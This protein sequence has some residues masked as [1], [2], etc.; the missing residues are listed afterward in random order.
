[1]YFAGQ[2]NKRN[3]N[4]ILEI[5]NYLEKKGVEYKNA[6]YTSVVRDKGKIVATGSCD[7][8]V[9]KYFFV[10]EKY[11]GQG[12]TILIYNDI[13]N[14]LYDNNISEY[15]VFTKPKNKNIFSS[16]GLKEVFQNQD[17]LLLEGGFSDYNSWIESIRSKLDKNAK[18]RGAIV[19]NCNPMTLGHKYLFE[20]AKDRVDELIIFIL[21]EDSSIFPTDYRFSIVKKEM[22]KFE[23]IKVFLS[24]RYMIS[25]ATFPTYFLKEKDN[26][27]DIYTNLDSQI[28]SEKIAKDLNIDIRFLGTEPIDELTNRYNYMLIK[29]FNESNKKIEI[30]ERLKD[31]DRVISASEVRNLLAEGNIDLAKSLLPK[32]TIEFLDSEAGQNIIAKLQEMRKKN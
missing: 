20:Y 32:S 29:N 28:F 23:N 1:M 5:K 13:L 9:L 15:F 11:L 27:L 4:E 12:L 30:I 6:D 25:K 8:S 16:L 26:S 3:Q 2:I 21:E 31:S 10:D 7:G 19:A 24:G 17:V 14:Y 22:Q 18:T